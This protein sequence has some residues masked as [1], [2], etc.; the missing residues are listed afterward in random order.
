[1]AKRRRAIDDASVARRLSEGRGQ[2]ERGS[3]RPWL[4][5]QDVPSLGL[6]SR[7]LGWKTGREHPCCLGWSAVTSMS[8]SG[9]RQ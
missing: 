8:S 3:Y 1:M 9:I 7:V 6:A 2:G 4:T 5:I